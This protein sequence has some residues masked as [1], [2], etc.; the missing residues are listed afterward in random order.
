LRLLPCSLNQTPAKCRRLRFKSGLTLAILMRT[1]TGKLMRTYTGNPAMRWKWMWLPGLL[2]AAPFIAAAN[3][4][5]HS[6]PDLCRTERSFVSR[7]WQRGDYKVPGNIQPL[8]LASIHGNTTRVLSILATMPPSELE[9]WQQLALYN[10][11]LFGRTATVDALLS[12]GANANVRTLIPAFFICRQ[13][14]RSHAVEDYLQSE[15]A[16]AG[17]TRIP[18]PRCIAPAHTLGPVLVA[19]L[20]CHDAATVEALLRHGA[21][22]MQPL[23]PRQ[24]L[25]KGYD[26]VPDPFIEAVANGDSESTQAFLAHGADPCTENHRLAHNWKLMKQRMPSPPTLASIGEKE[27]LPPALVQRLTCHEPRASG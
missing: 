22:P 5:H 2:I 18:A 17:D 11:T 15:D 10:A 12:H 6:N 14:L 13:S 19:A 23:T 9:R 21:D 1:Y 26:D 7:S 20:E 4:A 27:G 25:P 3:G 8:M 24:D 16:T